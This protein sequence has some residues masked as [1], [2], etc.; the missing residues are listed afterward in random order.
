MTADIRLGVPPPMNSVGVL[1]VDYLVDDPAFR[2]HSLATNARQIHAQFARKA[3][4]KAE[5]ELAVRPFPQLDDA[6]GARRLAALDA[7]LAAGQYGTALDEARTLIALSLRG[8]HY[9]QTYV[10]PRPL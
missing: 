10:P 9:Y 8:L 4:L 6:E 3:A 1:P 7:A 5:T 2:A